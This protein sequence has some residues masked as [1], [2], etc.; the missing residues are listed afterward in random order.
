MKSNN[1]LFALA[2]CFVAIFASF[3]FAQ[4]TNLKLRIEENLIEIKRLIVME[5]SLMQAA[6]DKLTVENSILAQENDRLRIVIGNRKLAKRKEKTAYRPDLA[7]LRRSAKLEAKKARLN[8]SLQKHMQERPVIEAPAEVSNPQ[9]SYSHSAN[10]Q[11]PQN[12]GFIYRK[13]E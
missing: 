6:N 5:Q 11:K 7:G 8:K 4:D 9:D 3:V 1:N 10:L 13:T 2:V 12:R